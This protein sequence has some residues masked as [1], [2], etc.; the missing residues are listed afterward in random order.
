MGGMSKK[1]PALAEVPGGME[2]EAA[3]LESLCQVPSIG[4]VTLRPGQQG[5]KN[6]HLQVGSSLMIMARGL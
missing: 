4:K 5:T 3:V 6:T 1:L 2:V